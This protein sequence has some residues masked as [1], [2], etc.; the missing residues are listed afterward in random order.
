[1]GPLAGVRVL[2]N[3]ATTQFFHRMTAYGLLAM[4]LWCAWRFRAAHWSLFGL[5]AGLVA[6]QAVLGIATLM[7]AAPLDMSLTHQ[8]L[9]VILVLAATRLI[10]TAH[11]AA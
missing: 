10:W 3:E 8:G 6:A 2:E 11:G 5:F 9:G 4:A 1:M 7:H